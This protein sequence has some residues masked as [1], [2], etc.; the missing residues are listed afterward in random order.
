MLD[1]VSFGVYLM[2]RHPENV[3]E[4]TLNE[5]VAPE[6]LMGKRAPL[7]GQLHRSITLPGEI[8][9]SGEPLEHL[10][11]GWKGDPERLSEKRCGA[12]KPVLLEAPDLLEVVLNPPGG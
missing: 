5:P 9:L 1:P 3:R 12:L 10:A 2:P 7:G 4:K 6:D 11:R 8:R